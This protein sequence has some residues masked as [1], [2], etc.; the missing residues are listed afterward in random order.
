M[1]QCKKS[2][3]SGSNTIYDTLSLPSPANNTDN[4]SISNNYS[5]LN[6]NDFQSSND[7]G[8]LEGS[9]NIS[10]STISSVLGNHS[11]VTKNEIQ[12][13]NTNQRRTEY[14]NFCFQKQWSFLVHCYSQKSIQF[15]FKKF[16]N[17]FILSSIFP[18]KLI[19]NNLRQ[20]VTVT[21]TNKQ[22]N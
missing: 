17:R 8:R 6:I 5:S 10:L 12:Y 18:N 16:M 2:T 21:T 3:C 13:E 9:Q 7:N 11:E 20:M 14:A 22:C 15:L 4:A 1:T 19:L